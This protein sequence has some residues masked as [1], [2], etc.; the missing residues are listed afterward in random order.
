MEGGW[1]IASMRREWSLVQQTTKLSVKADVPFTLAP[2]KELLPFCPLNTRFTSF[3]G[4]CDT[5]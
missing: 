3:I 5:K 2:K 1:S 4:H